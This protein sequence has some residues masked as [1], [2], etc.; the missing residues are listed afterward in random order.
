MCPLREQLS[1]A[2]LDYGECLKPSYFSS[3]IQSGFATTHILP[4]ALHGC[5]P[6]PCGFFAHRPAILQH[7]SLNP[8]PRAGHLF[9]RANPAHIPANNTCTEELFACGRRR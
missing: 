3:K 2:M 8:A 9:K 4:S 6:D 7:G 5:L 1:A